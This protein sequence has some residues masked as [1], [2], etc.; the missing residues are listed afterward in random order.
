MKLLSAMAV[1]AAL[2]LGMGSF[3]TN[4]GSFVA[5]AQAKGKK[6]VKKKGPGE[7][8]TFNYWKKGKCIDARVT[9]VKK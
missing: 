9:P 6:K 2:T 1:A 8:G 5:E 3:V 4:P 7:C